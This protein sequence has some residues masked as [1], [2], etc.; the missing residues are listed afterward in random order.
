MLSIGRDIKTNDYVYLDVSRS[1][2]AL[3]CG[4]RGSGKSYTL[5]VIVEELHQAGNVL[6]VI[7]DPMGIYYPLAQ[8][9]HSQDRLLWDWGLSAQALPTL[10]LVPGDPEMPVP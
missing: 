4:K 6:T 7:I 3:I 5:G 10:L 1:R 8:P 9:N 2:A